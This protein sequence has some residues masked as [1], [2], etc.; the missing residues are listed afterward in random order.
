[1]TS[2]R[3]SVVAKAHV[4]VLEGEEKQTQTGISWHVLKHFSP[5]RK[6]VVARR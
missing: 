6:Q 4:T 3:M 1:M 5:E 2:C